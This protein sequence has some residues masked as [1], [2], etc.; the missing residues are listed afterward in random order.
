MGNVKSAG[1]RNG[2][3]LSVIDAQDRAA[4]RASAEPR[5]RTTGH[6]HYR[7]IVPTPYGCLQSRT[8]PPCEVKFIN[9]SGVTL[10]VNWVNFEGHRV[11]YSL[12]PGD[13]HCCKLSTFN[14]HPWILEK[15]TGDIFA[16]YIG[17]APCPGAMRDSCLRTCPII[18]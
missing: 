6:P 13:G 9:T 12:L 10:R 4:E 7:E 3:N 11:L 16:V 17:A 15:E 1:S 5:R 18:C 14:N 2:T 8:A